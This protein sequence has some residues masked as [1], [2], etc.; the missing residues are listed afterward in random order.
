MRGS[1]AA[2]DIIC[3]DI[4]TDSGFMHAFIKAIHPALSSGTALDELKSNALQMLSKSLNSIVSQCPK[5]VNMYESIR[6]ELLMATTHTV[7]GPNNPLHDPTN[8][9]DWL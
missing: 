2:L 8:E 5:L 1:K 4:V 6:H 3:V 7:Y 9:A